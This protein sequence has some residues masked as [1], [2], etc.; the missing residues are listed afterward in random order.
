MAEEKKERSLEE[1]FKGLEEILDFY[2]LHGSYASAILIRY[3]RV[4]AA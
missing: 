2:L 4:A 3:V 1:N